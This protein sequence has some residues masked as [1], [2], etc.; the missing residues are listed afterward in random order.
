MENSNEEDEEGSLD[1]LNSK[2]KS[3]AKQQ[4]TYFKTVLEKATNMEANTVPPSDGV[5]G[6][7][8]YVE[9]FHIIGEAESKHMEELELKNVEDSK[10][11]NTEEDDTKKGVA[12]NNME[13][14]DDDKDTKDD[15]KSSNNDEL[16]NSSVKDDNVSG[17]DC[18]SHLKTKPKKIY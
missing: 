1:E 14:D 17:G 3:N 10:N 7:Q 9:K 2:N 16:V 5:S 15:T 13:E 12:R 8:K 4:E 18:K 11:D 6:L